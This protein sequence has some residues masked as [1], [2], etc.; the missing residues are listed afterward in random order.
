MLF[1]IYSKIMKSSLTVESFRTDTIFILNI[2]IKNNSAK[3]KVEFWFLFSTYY[4]MKLY[5]CSQFHE[6]TDDHFKVIG[7][8][9]F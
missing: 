9:R 4:P 8:I 7:W 6:N 1:H 2:P 3:E 5:I